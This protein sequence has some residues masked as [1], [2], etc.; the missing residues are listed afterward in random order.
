MGARGRRIFQ[1]KPKS[2]GKMNNKKPPR[3]VAFLPAC[4]GSCLGKR[5]TQTAGSK[6]CQYV[7]LTPLPIS[8][9]CDFRRFY[10][11]AGVSP[12][13]E[14]LTHA[15]ETPALHSEVQ[16]QAAFGM[17]RCFPTKNPFS[18]NQMKYPAQYQKPAS[19][20]TKILQIGNCFP[21]CNK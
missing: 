18:A 17:I 13:I 16:K 4:R 12:A 21:I 10:G 9:K 5:K 8:R 20:Q 1:G 2:D 19:I 14:G 3:I 11:R 15:G 7:G 6:K